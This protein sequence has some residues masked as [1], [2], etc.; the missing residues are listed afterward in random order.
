MSGLFKLVE[1]LKASGG[2]HVDE[3]PCMGSP[4]VSSASILMLNGMCSRVG[5]HGL[6][7]LSLVSLVCTRGGSGMW[8]MASM[9]FPKTDSN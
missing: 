6:L 2:M 7:E 8:H 3:Q 9:L 1:C 5:G 4:A